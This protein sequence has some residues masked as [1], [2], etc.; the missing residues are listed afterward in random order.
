MENR[1][2][3]TA[4][5]YYNTARK[6]FQTPLRLYYK[7]GEA[8]RLTMDYDK[9]EFFYQ[10]VITENDS[11]NLSVEFPS[12]YKNFV[13]VA[14]SNGNLFSSQDL[15][16]KLLV[17]SNDSILK[18][19]ATS[20]LKTIDWVIKN[21]NPIYGTYVMNLGRNVNNESSQTGN[22]VLG[23]SLLF[24]SNIE[25]TKFEKNGITY[26]QDAFQQIFTS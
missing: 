1:E 9:A 13:E 19:Y 3:E 24:I 26:Y 4:L 23:D 2:Y 18:N 14:I 8:C 17:G 21:N 7:M 20:K 25:Y 12:F 6:F 11:I 15:L 10:K 16:K 22:C 5:G